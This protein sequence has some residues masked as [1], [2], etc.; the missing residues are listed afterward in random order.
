MKRIIVSILLLFSALLLIAQ[1]QTI[2]LL[3]I[4]TR[5]DTVICGGD[6][7]SPIFFRVDLITVENGTAYPDTIEQTT[8]YKNGSCPADSL[9][10]LRQLQIEAENIQQK[11]SGLMS[12]SFEYVRRGHGVYQDVR[13]AYNDL[14]GSDLYYHFEDAYAGKFA[15]AGNTY[16]IVDIQDGASSVLATMIR[17]GALDRYRLEVNTGEPGAGTRYTVIPLSPTSFQINNWTRSGGAATNYRLYLD[18]Q[19]DASK[20]VYRESG[21]LYG[22][23]DDELRIIKVK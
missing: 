6:T 17:V 21:Y 19:A 12:R 16:R 23:T 22:S 10:V 9:E 3:E 5:S 7:I 18:R 4:T 15:G 11:A 1:E 20:P 13:S 2:E 8:L 14:T